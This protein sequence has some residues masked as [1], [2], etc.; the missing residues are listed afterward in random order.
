MSQILVNEVINN[1]IQDFIDKYRYEN[2]DETDYIDVLFWISQIIGQKDLEK[3]E[4]ELQKILKKILNEMIK[5]NGQFVSVNNM[6]MIG[7]LGQVAFGINTI[8]KKLSILEDLALSINDIFLNLWD[9][10]IDYMVENPI[11]FHCYD[12]IAGAS[13]ALYYILDCDMDVHN[14]R[15]VQ[16]LIEFLIYLSK[17]YKFKDQYIIRY[18]IKKEQQFQEEEK[19]MMPDGHINFGMAHGIMGPLLALAKAYSMKFRNKGLKVTIVNLIGLYEKF[20]DKTNGVLKY[21]RRLS[22]E[23]YLNDQKSDITVNSGWCYGNISLVRGLM[24]SEKYIGD[25]EMYNYYKSELLKII[26]Q[27]TDLYNLSSPIL[28]HGYSSVITIQLAAFRETGDICFF[29]LLE[30]NLALLM[31]EH[32]ARKN[33]I[34]YINNTSLLLGSGGVILTL[35][36]SQTKKCEYN[37]LLMMD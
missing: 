22:I 12:A 29:N 13:G 33:D 37:H 11:V 30:R 9:E 35:L 15:R 10:I 23:D 3:Y 25:L 24:K 36:E 8:S 16:K 34:Q 18:H 2:V 14:D 20:S 1:Y 19:V 27:P 26:A 6:G 31:K 7:G 32:D 4:Y 17:N 21:P 28:C 5:N